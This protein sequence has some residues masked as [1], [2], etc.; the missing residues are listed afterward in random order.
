MN[1]IEQYPMPRVALF[2][3]YALLPIV[4][5]VDGTYTLVVLVFSGL[6]YAP[7]A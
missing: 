1:R 2:Q 7:H 3:N 5:V 4:S 6:D